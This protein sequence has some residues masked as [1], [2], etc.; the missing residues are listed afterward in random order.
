M[1]LSRL[2]IETREHHLRVERDLG[3]M[4]RELGLEAY[5]AVLSRL[6]SFHSSWEPR[7]AAL[8]DDEMFFGPR[9]KLHLIERDLDVLGIE[10]P[11]AV[12]ACVLPALGDHVDAMGSLYVLEG[13]TLGGQ[14][15]AEHVERRLG[16]AR[17]EGSAYFRSYGKR[18]AER[19]R[20][21]QALLLEMSS[22][23]TDDAIVASAIATFDRLH[24]WLCEPVPLA[25]EARS[26]G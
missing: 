9:R 12:S 23:A 21:F 16:L 14:I 2:K 5:G 19:W 4:D 6:F 13:A 18:V 20:A 10:K 7:V 22:P 3:I 1:I 25:M 8:L 17:G 24:A 15:V 11:R 26:H